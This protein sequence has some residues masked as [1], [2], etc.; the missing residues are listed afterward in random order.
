[1]PRASNCA[2][3]IFLKILNEWREEIREKN[4]ENKVIQVMGKAITSLKQHSD[5]IPT[6]R[7]CQPLPYFGPWILQGLTE[8]YECVR[9][10]E[11]SASPPRPTKRKKAA[12]AP[13]AN[14]DDADPPAKKPRGRPKKAQPLEDSFNT[15][16]AG[17]SKKVVVIPK[18]VPR[19]AAPV[20]VLGW[21]PYARPGPSGP[22]PSQR[23]VS[24]RDVRPPPGAMIPPP[25][26]EFLFWYLDT[27]NV[28]VQS[29]NQAAVVILDDCLVCYAIEFP[30]NCSAHPI[31]RQLRSNKVAPRRPGEGQTL[32]AVMPEHLAASRERCTA[33]IALA[34]PSRPTISRAS[35]SSSLASNDDSL[36]ELL[37]EETRSKV[38]SI[39]PTRQRS[40]LPQVD[41][42][43]TQTSL[44][45]T[46]SEAASTSASNRNMGRTT[47]APN[48]ELFP[49][50]PVPGPARTK[51]P[52][53]VASTP[54]ASAAGP[55]HLARTMS[56]PLPR[57]VSFDEVQPMRTTNGISK[58][59]KAR[60][61]SHIPP[62]PAIDQQ[63][64]RH[65]DEEAG[66]HVASDD[67]SS[68]DTFQ[69]PFTP[70]V[71]PANSYEVI[72]ILD[73]REVKSTKNR[74]YIETGLRR[75]GVP[76][77][78]RA[79]EIGDMCWIGR[80]RV[81][82]AEYVL[83]YIIERK[84]IDDLVGSIKDGR[85]HEQKFRLKQSGIG[86][87]YYLVEEYTANCVHGSMDKAVFTALSS[88]QIVDG[89]FVKETRDIEDTIEYLA[90]L[91]H[92]IVSHY[93]G[94]PL[95]VIPDDAIHRHS[96]MALIARLRDGQPDTPFH[97]SYSAFRELNK[98]NTTT[99]R[100]A[101]AQML[102]CIRGMSAE[103]VATILE[104]YDTPR[105]L[106][107]AFRDAER[108]EEEDRAE[109][110]VRTA[111]GGKGR[112][113]K[114]QVI[115]ARHMLTRLPANGRREIKQA[116]AEQVY[117][118]FMSEQY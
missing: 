27:E 79:L 104:H 52:A 62:P 109:E 44:L 31:A 90:G 30:G 23:T 50:S 41:R 96:H 112:R 115:S 100:D 75:L 66:I 49:D 26:T 73:T 15:S 61:S 69:L 58:K 77:D 11:P 70:L 60:M 36:A 105:R 6:P 76:V 95:H 2:N 45:E 35:S 80:D 68:E 29:R 116:L 17:P 28:R 7:D 72:F 87:L 92:T 114:S 86:R 107:D 10:G 110:E 117:D 9:N 54:R 14:S 32:L 83:D 38:G 63:L 85:F 13:I 94:K 22:P 18:A 37:R 101:F 113:K 106:W 99:L 98:S 3:P 25:S 53:K 20:S 64:E 40:Q 24:A 97:T 89:F 103:K 33:S 47:S 21:D 55:S 34:P 102:L 39:D 1:M 78:K 65:L 84:R 118:L 16:S 57:E 42:L 67:A 5:P 88:A 48:A 56:A 8:R 59:R 12:E 19:T 71:L 81:T 4:P 74:E 43:R 111:E 51:P 108:I 82:G 91:H 46:T 93:S